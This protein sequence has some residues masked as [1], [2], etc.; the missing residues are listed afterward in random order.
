MSRSRAG[1]GPEHVVAG[2]EDVTPL[3]ERVLAL[4]AR[5]ADALPGRA[6]RVMI[7]VAGPPGAGKSTLTE[8]LATAL[9]AAGAASA[10]VGM[11][12]YHLAQA[13][14]VRLGRA[15]RKG[16]PDTFDADGYVSLVRRIRVQRPG[17]GV[18]YAPA[19]DRHLEEPVAGA[20]PVAADVP[21]VLTEGNY[22]LLPDEPWDRLADLLDETW[23]LETD[24]AGRRARLVARHVAHG[25][26]PAAAAEWE[27]RSDQ[28]NAEV[29]AA[30][31]DRADVLVRWR[32][33]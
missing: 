3:V 9:A 4:L 28:R 26:S 11:D 21:V 6:G 16:A 5:S 7:G 12:G 19:F 29:V 15:D 32:E 10:V 14:L 23:Y 18:V 27:S 13:E 25:R 31:R 30:A 22:L 17:A 1:A 8:V 2:P 24:D 33:R 20:V